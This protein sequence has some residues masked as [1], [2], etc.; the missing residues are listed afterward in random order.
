MPHA[1][2]QGFG[3]AGAGDGVVLRLLD[4][5]PVVDAAG[6][7]FQGDVHFHAGQMDAAAVVCA[8]AE[9]HVA[10]RRG[11]GDVE[12]IRALDHGWVAVEGTHPP[13]AVSPVQV[14]SRADLSSWRPAG[15]P[16]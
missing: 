14:L 16:S 15:L 8:E 2:A 9:G 3:R 5:I 12:D 1:D 4:Q 6:E 7:R 10:R 11:A 13:G